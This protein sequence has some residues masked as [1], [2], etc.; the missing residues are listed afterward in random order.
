MVRHKVPASLSILKDGQ[1]GCAALKY[2]GSRVAAPL[3]VLLQNM[4]TECR[5]S[6]EAAEEVISRRDAIPVTSPQH[7]MLGQCADSGP[8]GFMCELKLRP[9][10][11]TMLVGWLTGGGLGCVRHTQEVAEA[12]RLVLLPDWADRNRHARWAAAWSAA[13]SPE[14]MPCRALR[15]CQHAA[16]AGLEMYCALGGHL[17]R[18]VAWWHSRCFLSGLKAQL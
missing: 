10:A 15:L 16:V 13:T 2:A 18:C 7:C 4:F 11:A 1:S 14:S 3:C 12:A 9:A 8:C 17:H 5:E 6:V